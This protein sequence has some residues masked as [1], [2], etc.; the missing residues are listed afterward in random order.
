MEQINWPTGDET[1]QIV[2]KQT[3]TVLLSVSRGKD[4]LAMWLACKPFFK[5][6]VP[7]HMQPLPGLGWCEDYLDYLEDKLGAEIIRVLNPNTI[8][9]LNDLIYQTPESSAVVWAHNWPKHYWYQ[10]AQSELKKQLKLPATAWSGF[11]IR[12]ED[13]Q[14]RKFVLRK[15][16]PISTERHEFKPVWDW[17]LTRVCQVIRDSGLKLPVDYRLMDRSWEDWDYKYM[18]LI[19]QYFPADYE[20]IAKFFPLLEADFARHEFAQARREGRSGGPEPPGLSH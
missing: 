2:A 5:R 4:S 18:R 14:L 10:R 1:I 20:R 17:K 6:I 15:W 8:H 9:D 13:S 12:V 3:D 19:E 11:G 7:V 16:G